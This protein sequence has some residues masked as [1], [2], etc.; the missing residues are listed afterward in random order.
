MLLLP[1]DKFT[2][3]ESFP[4]DATPKVVIFS[5]GGDLLNVTQRN[6][7]FPEDTEISFYSL[8]SLLPSSKC[9]Q[10]KNTTTRPCPLKTNQQDL[11]H[12]RPECLE[13]ALPLTH[14]SS[15]PNMGVTS[16]CKLSI[17]HVHVCEAKA[18]CS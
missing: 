1:N 2:K 10:T 7:R 16:S 13:P 8:L 6:D 12:K 9:D 15:G 5:L 17:K 14:T 18:T 3:K 4:F 11:I